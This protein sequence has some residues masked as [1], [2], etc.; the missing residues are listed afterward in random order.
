VWGTPTRIVSIA[1]TGFAPFLSDYN[2]Y[3]SIIHGG[4]SIYWS[5]DGPSGWTTT[6]LTAALGL[7]S[8]AR[9][10]SASTVDGTTAVHPNGGPALVYTDGTAAPAERVQYAYRNGNAWAV[11]TAADV[12][13][14]STNGGITVGTPIIEFMSGNA[15]VVYE[16]IEGNG[17][18]ALSTI[19]LNRRAGPG[20]WSA[21]NLLGPDVNAVAARPIGVGYLFLGIQAVDTATTPYG[22]FD[23]WAHVCA[24]P[25]CP[26]GSCGNGLHDGREVDSDC[27]GGGT[28]GVCSNGQTCLANADCSTGKCISGLCAP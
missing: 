2:G 1:E 8:N 24:G 6:N 15:S 7:T 21:R 4:G 19:W 27:G 17:T 23:A 22:W 13:A 12:G 28:C 25:E 11:E 14:A 16:R 3:A 18:P 9:R 5:L 20:V 10:A 26:T